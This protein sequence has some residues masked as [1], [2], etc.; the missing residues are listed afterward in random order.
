MNRINNNKDNYEKQRTTALFIVTSESFF[1]FEPIV[2]GDQKY[3]AVLN[4]LTINN[5]ARLMT[6]LKLKRVD[7][8]L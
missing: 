3:G 8:K 6:L 2:I 5:Q 7:E 1:T 4:Q